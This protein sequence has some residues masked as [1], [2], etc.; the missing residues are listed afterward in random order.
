MGVLL[1]PQAETAPR[2]RLTHAFLTKH[3]AKQVHLS[4][5]SARTLLD[6]STPPTLQAGRLQPHHAETTPIR[7]P[8]T[9][10]KPTGSG[11]PPWMSPLTCPGCPLG[12][13]GT[14]V[15]ARSRQLQSLAIPRLSAE[16]GG[17]EWLLAETLLK[18]PQAGVGVSVY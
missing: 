1:H 2:T 4:Q 12:V 18:G 6:A 13:V 10:F 7:V 8:D 17:F 15:R 14:L 3:E 16:K 9:G 5:D 11:H